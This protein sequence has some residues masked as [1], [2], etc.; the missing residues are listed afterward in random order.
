[1]SPTYVSREADID[2]EI[3]ERL[4]QRVNDDPAKPWTVV[5]DVTED[6][7][8]GSD[9]VRETLRQLTLKGSITI[10]AGGDLRAVVDAVDV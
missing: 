2:E 10:A 5:A 8:H 3:A 9:V 7:D 4:L 6:M 1:M